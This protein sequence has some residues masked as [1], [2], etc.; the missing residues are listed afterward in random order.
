MNTAN[1]SRSLLNSF[2]YAFAGMFYVFTSQRNMRIHV[3]IATIAFMMATTLRVSLADWSML[4]LTTTLVLFAEAINTSIESVVD[5]ASPEHHELARVAKDVAAGAV[6]ITAF[7]AVIVGLIV[8]GPP[9][10]AVLL[11]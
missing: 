6:L 4:V 9:L 1:R 2:R 8:L 7:G 3:I 11:S 10:W 5:L